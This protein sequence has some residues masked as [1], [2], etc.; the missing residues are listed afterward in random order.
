MLHGYT[1]THGERKRRNNIF[2]IFHLIFAIYF[3]RKSE[4]EEEN[5]SG[6]NPSPIFF[7]PAYNRSSM[8]P[9]VRKQVLVYRAVSV[10]WYSLVNILLNVLAALMSVCL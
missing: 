4:E 10:Y 9:D 1:R 7:P 3:S 8:Y 2:L 6:R 5:R